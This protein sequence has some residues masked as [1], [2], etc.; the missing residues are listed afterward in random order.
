MIHPENLRSA[1]KQSANG[2]VK[3]IDNTITLDTD[4]N[5]ETA[6]QL[7]NEYALAE[8]ITPGDLVVRLDEDLDP[9]PVVAVG[10]D[11]LTLDF[12]GR[13]SPRLDLTNYKI[14]R[15]WAPG[16]GQPTPPQHMLPFENRI[17][18]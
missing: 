1:L 15:K 7:L 5:A 11:W 16:A 3:M 12:W 9:R 4:V 17:N 18:R 13:E 10:L 6:C 14:W 2:H 8:T